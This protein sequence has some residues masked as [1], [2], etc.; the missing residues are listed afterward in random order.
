MQTFIHKFLGSLTPRGGHHFDGMVTAARNCLELAYRFNEVDASA[1]AEAVE[2]RR[3]PF[4]V[5][6]VYIHIYLGATITTSTLHV[7]YL[8]LR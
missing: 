5:N 8:N 7:S 3:M 1:W 6:I 4:L 2:Y